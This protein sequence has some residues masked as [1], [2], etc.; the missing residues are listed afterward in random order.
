MFLDID[1][2]S[3]SFRVSGETTLWKFSSFLARAVTAG[4]LHGEV[5]VI[6]SMERWTI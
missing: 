1:W 5:S 6:T 4:T 2:A 3:G